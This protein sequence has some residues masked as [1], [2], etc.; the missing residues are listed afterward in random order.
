MIRTMIQHIME[1]KRINDFVPTLCVTKHL[2]KFPLFLKLFDPIEQVDGRNATCWG[3][4]CMVTSIGQK[5]QW[6]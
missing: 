2:S 4:K 6:C 1:S 5:T 3:D